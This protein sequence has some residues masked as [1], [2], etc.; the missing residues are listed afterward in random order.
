[1]SPE[2]KR[3]LIRI[4][5]KF[6]RSIDSPK[7]RTMQKWN[8]S[9]KGKAAQRRYIESGKAA[10]TR[11]LRRAKSDVDSNRKNKIRDES[12]VG[13][14]MARRLWTKNLDI[15]LLRLVREG[16]TSRE[17]GDLMGRSLQSI[18]RRRQR[19]GKSGAES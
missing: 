6:L 18:E 10:A 3:E 17:I 13:K 15:E 19:I 4:R 5:Q 9:E 12:R 1:M 8:A 2:E 14:K 7:R 11:R 16:K